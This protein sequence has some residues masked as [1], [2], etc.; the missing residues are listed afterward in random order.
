MSPSAAM[1]VKIG[2][3]WMLEVVTPG[4]NVRRH[5][6]VSMLTGSGRLVVSSATR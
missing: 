3:Q 1:S 4:D 2:S 6:S 5:V